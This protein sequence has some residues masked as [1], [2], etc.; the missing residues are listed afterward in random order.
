MDWWIIVM[1]WFLDKHIETDSEGKSALPTWTPSDTRLGVIPATSL[2]D[3]RAFVSSFRDCVFNDVLYSLV[4]DATKGE[5]Q[6]E[7][8]KSF[9]HFIL[10][11]HEETSARKTWKNNLSLQHRTGSITCSIFSGGFGG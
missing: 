4:K 11:E 2:D 8:L 7:K 10:K 6:E 1:P 3:S 5:P 9:V